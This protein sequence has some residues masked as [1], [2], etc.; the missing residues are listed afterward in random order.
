[1]SSS[2]TPRVYFEH[3]DVL[4]CVAALMVLFAHAF[5]HVVSHFGYP[6]FMR[7]GDTQNLTFAGQIGRAHV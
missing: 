5:E 6:D 1:M 7:I 3:L 4:R 2:N